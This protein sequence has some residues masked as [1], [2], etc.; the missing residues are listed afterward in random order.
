M[1]KTKIGKVDYSAL[2][3]P[4]EKHERTTANYFAKKGLDVT[5]V[6][7]SSV[8]GTNNP[9]CIINGRIWEFKSPTTY[10]ESSFEYNFKKAISQSKNII[11]DLRR[12]N[13]RDEHKYLRELIK[14]GDSR[15]IKSLIAITK[16]GRIVDIKGK[17]C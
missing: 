10:S 7:P 3:N 9:D 12:L 8:K 2:K 15:T 5:F 11:F 1:K 14:R 17:V 16:D 4:P 13:K 6:K